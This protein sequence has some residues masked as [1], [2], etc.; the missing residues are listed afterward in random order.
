MLF[1]EIHGD[2][3]R[4]GED[5]QPSRGLEIGDVE[6]VELSDGLLDGLYRASPEGTGQAT[7]RVP[8]PVAA[9]SVS[10]TVPCVAVPQDNHGKS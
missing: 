1:A 10:R 9:A 5:P 7:E 6:V 4:E 2:L 8:E 3:S